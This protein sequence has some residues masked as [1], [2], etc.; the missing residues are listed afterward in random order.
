MAKIF[1][2]LNEAA[3]LEDSNYETLKKKEFKSKFRQV[4][5]SEFTKGGL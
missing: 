4:Y 5:L 1:L 3:E 2:T